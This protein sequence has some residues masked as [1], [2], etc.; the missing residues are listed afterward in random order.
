LLGFKFHD[1]NSICQPAPNIQACSPKKPA[2]KRTTTM[3]PMM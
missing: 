1:L 2:T 3:T